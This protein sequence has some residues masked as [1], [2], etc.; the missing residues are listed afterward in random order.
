LYFVLATGL[1]RL[2]YLPVGLALTLVY[3]GV[4]MA[5]SGWVEVPVAVSLAVVAVLIGGTIGASLVR[6][7]TAPSA[8]PPPDR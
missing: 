3:V 7:K 5:A 1:H 8:P 4:K 2:T 6:S